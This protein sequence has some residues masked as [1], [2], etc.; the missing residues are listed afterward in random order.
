MSDRPA[1]SDDETLNVL[2]ISR[3]Q[4]ERSRIQHVSLEFLLGIR[5]SRRKAFLIH[6][7]QRLEILGLKIT[8]YRG[9]SDIVKARCHQASGRPF[10]VSKRLGRASAQFSTDEFA[11][12]QKNLLKALL[13]SCPPRNLGRTIGIRGVAVRLWVV[14]SPLTL[15][16][17]LWAWGDGISSLPPTIAAA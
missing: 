5:D 16:V 1:L 8:E 3:D 9:H 6:L 12:R 15:C 17:P 13:S 14:F 2:F 11:L 7:P 4:R 10:L